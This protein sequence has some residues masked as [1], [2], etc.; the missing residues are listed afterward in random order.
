MDVYRDVY[1]CLCIDVEGMWE[2]KMRS[3][4]EGAVSYAEV[5]IDIYTY[6]FLLL[7]VLIVLMAQVA[8]ISGRIFGCTR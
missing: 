1:M 7:L 4:L 5:Y 3:L 8:D 2:T 6:L